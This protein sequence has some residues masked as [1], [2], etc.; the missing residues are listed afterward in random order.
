MGRTDKD[1][2]DFKKLKKLY[3]DF[4]AVPPY[5]LRRIDLSSCSDTLKQ[6][7]LY[8]RTTFAHKSNELVLTFMESIK[9]LK[10]LETLSIYKPFA[11]VNILDFIVHLKE[12]R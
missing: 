11:C 4:D 8:E 12:L 5:L 2:I 7:G 10:N 9:V 3:I 1:P 6:L